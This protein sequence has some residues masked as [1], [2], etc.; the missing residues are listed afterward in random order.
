MVDKIHGEL[1]ASD[2]VLKKPVIAEKD[3]EFI[4][5]EMEW[6]M[7]NREII[8]RDDTTGG[9]SGDSSNNTIFTVPE[10]NTLWLT[11]VNLSYISRPTGTSVIF[12]K[13]SIVDA[14]NIVTQL[15]AFIFQN[16]YTSEHNDAMTLSFTLPIKVSSNQTIRLNGG[17]GAGTGR[18]DVKGGFTGWIEPKVIIAP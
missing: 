2:T 6:A 15:L 13:I 18:L 5:T 11:S 7:R 3:R 16:G 9:A 14:G 4:P 1:G 12:P 8:S 10:N 17:L